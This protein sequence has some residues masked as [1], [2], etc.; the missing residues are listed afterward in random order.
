MKVEFAY[1]G[2]EQMAWEPFAP[3]GVTL[4]AGSE[5]KGIPASAFFAKECK[6]S[7]RVRYIYGPRLSRAAFLYQ[8]IV[9]KLSKVCYTL[10]HKVNHTQMLR[11]QA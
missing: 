4:G 2:Y 6:Y 11:Y 8:K 3:V 10:I 9:D 7:P 5:L 1:A